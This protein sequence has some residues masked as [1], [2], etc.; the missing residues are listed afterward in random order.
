MQFLEDGNEGCFAQVPL[1]STGAMMV[2]RTLCAQTQQGRDFW[3]E[4]QLRYRIDGVTMNP[5][6]SD[7]QAERLYLDLFLLHAVHDLAFWF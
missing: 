6:C 5:T 3:P 7:R 2:V 1:G 4:A